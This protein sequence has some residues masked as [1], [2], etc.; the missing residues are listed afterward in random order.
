VDV[1]RHAIRLREEIPHSD[2]RLVPGAGHMVHHAV[3]GRVAEA[4][5]AVAAWSVGL[6]QP[7]PRLAAAAE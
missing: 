4:I 3:P 2:L 5:E 1:G 7:A 6:P